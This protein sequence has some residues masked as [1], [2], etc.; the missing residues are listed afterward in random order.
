MKLINSLSH[1]PFKTGD[2]LY[3]CH[4]AG[5]AHFDASRLPHAVKVGF[6]PQTHDFHPW[7]LARLRENV[8]EHFE[9]PGF[10]NNTPLNVFCNPVFYNGVLS[11]VHANKLYKARIEN[12]LTLNPELVKTGLFTGFSVGK[13]IVTAK[14]GCS[15]EG[16]IIRIE[17]NGGV[18][19]CVLPMTEVVRIIPYNDAYIITGKRDNLMISILWDG[20]SDTLRITSEGRDV[21]KCCLD[22]DHVIHAVKDPIFD[23]R[24]LHRTSVNLAPL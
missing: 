14:P 19:E 13:K 23:T 22:G 8:I 12:S 21:Y 17:N 9:V 2:D 11:F 1:M 18:S 3:F 5:I 7:Q 6:V 4:S 15:G 10:L 24:F 20:V 16:D